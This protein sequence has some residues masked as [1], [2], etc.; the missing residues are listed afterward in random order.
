MSSLDGKVAVVTGAASGI[1]K[2]IALTLSKAGASVALTDLNVDRANAVAKEINA[3]G[4]KALGVLM[5][6]TNE[7]R[8]NEGIDLVATA[9][10]TIDILISNAGIQIVNPI[11]NFRFSDWKKMQAI[12]VDGA[13][14][15][16]K[17]ALKYMY[18]GDQGGVVIYMGSVYS[19]EAAPLKAAY[20]TASHG[21]LGLARTLAHEGGT[22]NVRSHVVCPGFVRTPLLDRQIPQLAKELGISEEDVV[23]TIMLG[24]TVDG[25][26]TTAEDV[27]R[28]VL[29][30]SSF[31]G[32]V[33]TGQSFLASHGWY[34]Q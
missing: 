13:F 30:L 8:V 17:A 24:D 23:R 9:F 16:T 27:A 3:T 25:E 4:G 20:V 19:H 15:T 2:E 18:R 33:L 10:G 6:V 5:D 7:E 22:R 28:T 29:F 26:F 14:L 32:P 34:M 11:D 1:G 31:P 12:Y 21:L